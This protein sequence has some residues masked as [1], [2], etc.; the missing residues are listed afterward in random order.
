[1][2]N[3][4]YGAKFARLNI[5]SCL[6]PDGEYIMSGSE[7]GKAYVWGTSGITINAEAIDI[8]FKGVLNTVDWNPKYHMA[9]LSGFGNEFPIVIFVWHRTAGDEAYMHD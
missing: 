1:M 7:D 6:S 3:R 8:N 4:F 9:A 5:K 2:I